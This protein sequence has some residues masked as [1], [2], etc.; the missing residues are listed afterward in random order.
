MSDE[1]IAKGKAIAES[2]K[3]TPRGVDLGRIHDEAVERCRERCR[4]AGELTVDTTVGSVLL[5]E[6]RDALTRYVA[7]ADH[8]AA[9]A[10]TLW[11]ATTHALPA[12]E[13]APTVGVD[14]SG[15]AVW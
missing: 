4:A 7:F 13:C 3:Y 5:D 6:L 15:E 12:F 9:A 2:G 14:E 11:I 10:V 8:H 1:M